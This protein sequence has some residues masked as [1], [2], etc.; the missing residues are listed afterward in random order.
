MTTIR[1]GSRA[2][3]APRT[4]QDY[5][6]QQAEAFLRR[7]ERQVRAQYWAMKTEG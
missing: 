2:E 5:R 7:N 4:L 1:T 3:P 6:R